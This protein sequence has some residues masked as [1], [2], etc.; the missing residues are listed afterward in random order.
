MK[1]PA[2]FR[3]VLESTPVSGET[4]CLFGILGLWPAQKSGVSVT[5]E[6]EGELMTAKDSSAGPTMY[7]APPAPAV[8]PGHPWFACAVSMPSAMA[9]RA[10]LSQLGPWPRPTPPF[11][12]CRRIPSRRLGCWAPRR[13]LRPRS[14]MWVLQRRVR[15]RTHPHGPKLLRIDPGAS[16]GVARGLNDMVA[17][18]RRVRARPF[19]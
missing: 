9:Y 15:F 10:M 16:H 6:Y 8:T 18:P 7:A 12:L 4:Q 5:Y 3:N 17:H 11:R 19:P 14:L 13:W 1:A 2:R